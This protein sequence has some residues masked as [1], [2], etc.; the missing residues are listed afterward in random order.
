MFT[1]RR[2]TDRQPTRTRGA[3]PQP[4]RNPVEILAKQMSVA[5]LARL[6][7][8]W[9]AYGRARDN[10]FR[11]VMTHRIEDEVSRFRQVS[12]ACT[13]FQNWGENARELIDKRLSDAFIEGIERGHSP[14]DVIV[15]MQRIP[16]SAATA[17]FV[18]ELRRGDGATAIAL[19][20][21]ENGKIAPDV[22]ASFGEEAD[23][24][25]KQFEPRDW[26]D[27]AVPLL[28][29]SPGELRDELMEAARKSMRHTLTDIATRK[30]RNATREAEARQAD[31]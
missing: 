24:I 11:L 2:D 29:I 5:R 10:A 26:A 15:K 6:S 23:D 21:S 19:L 4:D 12:T 30:I 9:E 7:G 8:D 13:G 3:R 25:A 14:H 16:R 31:A 17:A 27:F 18:S 22:R 1:R 20:L 28:A